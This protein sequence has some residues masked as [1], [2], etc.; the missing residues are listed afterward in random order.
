MKRVGHQSKTLLGNTS[1]LV[2]CRT[3][4]S[5]AEEVMSPQA[6]GLTS[7]RSLSADKNTRAEKKEQG[8]SEQTTNREG[9]PK[10]LKLGAREMM[11]ASE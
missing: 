11:K 6:E 1:K 9:R 3:V 4:I 7:H 5:K 10:C 2:A 8:K